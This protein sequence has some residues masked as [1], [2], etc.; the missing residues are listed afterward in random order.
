[1]S[2]RRR[3]ELDAVF[4]Q[5]S[6]PAGSGRNAASLLKFWCFKS[7]FETSLGLWTTEE[8]SMMTQDTLLSRV[9][10]WTFSKV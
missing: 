5:S 7:V 1:M 2:G 8:C 3:D 9:L 10:R 6:G 4:G